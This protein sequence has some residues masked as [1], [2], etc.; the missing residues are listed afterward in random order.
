MRHERVDMPYKNTTK[1]HT[2]AACFICYAFDAIDFMLLALALPVIISEFQISMADAGLLGTGGMIGVGL[3]SIVVGW[4]SDNHGRRWALVVCVLIFGIFTAAVALGRN[5][6]E[7]FIL[8]FLAGL[9]L[10]G[11]W[12]V[13]MAFINETWPKEHRGRAASFVLSAWPI[14]FGAA[15][16]LAWWILPHF[17]W[18]VLFLCGLG[19][20]VAAIYIFIFV[21]E[22]VVWK[23]QK[24]TRRAQGE[25]EK[26]AISE[27]FATALL[28]RTV[29]G[30]LC[31]SCALTAYWGVN[32]WLPTYLVKERNLDTENMT[33]FIVMLN[34]GMFVGYQIFGYL[35]D[36]IGRRKA[37]ILL[38]A[39]AT[40]I[41]PIYAVTENHTVLFW[42]GSLVAI[43]FSYAGPFGSYFAELFPARVRSLGAGFCFN[44]GRGV[45][46][47]AP[48]ALG[49]IAAHYSLATGIALCAIGFCAASI[50]MGFLPET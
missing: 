6:T 1:W 35:A 20:V 33:L 3:S 11:V 36:K 44:V 23:Q 39:C 13:A 49:E 40:V 19:A 32:T 17:G 42:M 10:G 24:E 25:N 14:G 9:G 18:R 26:I 48:Y 7:L 12:G 37:L 29:L 31:A 2:L 34:V 28:K 45:A 41:L 21:P 46:A 8:R 16:L 5:W 22:S 38:F 15:A 27:I 4:Y 50:V 47:F 43:F 30:T